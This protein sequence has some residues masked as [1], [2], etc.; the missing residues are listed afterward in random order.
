MTLIDKDRF[1]VGIAERRISR[2]SARQAFLP[3]MTAN[4]I[5]LRECDPPNTPAA[6]CDVPPR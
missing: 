4:A 1:S 2:R 5:R 6:A 3:P